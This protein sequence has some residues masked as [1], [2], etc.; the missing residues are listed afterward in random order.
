MR[1]GEILRV[2]GTHRQLELSIR[3]SEVMGI[4][5]SYTA[6]CFDEAA[7]FIVSKLRDGEKPVMEIGRCDGPARYKRPSDLYNKYK[8]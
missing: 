3:P 7:A 8:C 4:T 6:F 1:S 5:D 2:I